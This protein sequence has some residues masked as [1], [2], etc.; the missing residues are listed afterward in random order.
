MFADQDQEHFVVQGGIKEDPLVCVWHLFAL[1]NVVDLMADAS[2]LICVFVRVEKLLRDVGTEVPLKTEV[3]HILFLL[4]ERPN[5][6][7]KPPACCFVFSPRFFCVGP[8]A[9]PKTC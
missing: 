7:P 5:R 6:L 3:V 2:S 4:P 9:V 8:P 1:H